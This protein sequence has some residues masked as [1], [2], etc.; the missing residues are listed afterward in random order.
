MQKPKPNQIANFLSYLISHNSG[1]PNRDL[2]LK[3]LNWTEALIFC[4]NLPQ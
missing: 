2:P 4:E 3:D 1:L